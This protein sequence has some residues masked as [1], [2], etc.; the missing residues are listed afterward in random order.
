MMQTHIIA[1]YAFHDFLKAAASSHML[2]PHHCIPLRNNLEI[3]HLRK[4]TKLTAN[5]L[6]TNLEHLRPEW[7]VIV[8]GPSASFSTGNV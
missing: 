7:S 8:C 6:Y 5:F 4:L 1:H 2:P 3:L